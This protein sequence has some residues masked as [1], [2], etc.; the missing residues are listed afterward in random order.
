M[1]IPKVTFGIIVLNGEPFIRYNLRA[2]YPFA[3]QIVV[4]E[5]ASPGAKHISTPDGHSTDETLNTLRDFKAH[6]DPEQKLLILTA[7]DEGYPNGF[8]PGEKHEQSQAYAKRATGDYLWQ[9]D[10]DEFYRP[11]D[12]AVVLDTLQHDE[13]ITALS[14]SQIT[15]WGGLDYITDGWFLRRGWCARGIHRV[16][17]WGPGYHYV[18]H[19]PVTI[20]NAQG[21]DVRDLHWVDGLEWARKGIYMYHYSLLFPKQVIEK[22]EYYKEADW[23][24]HDKAKQWAEESYLMLKKPYHVHNIYDYPSWLE[25]FLGKHPPQIETMYAD[26]RAGRIDTE[27]R[28]TGDVDRLL[29]SPGYR[30]GR[31]CLKFAEPFSHWWSPGIQWRGRLKRFVKDPR[32]SIR[33]LLHSD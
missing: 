17:K 20:H 33:K 12:M 32:S 31:A 8:W 21:V 10:M 1:D 26:I 29:R 5:G 11:E 23:A 13:S 2:L 16:F 6:E 15:F 25:R 3:H 7:E 19:R 28:S 30:L 22:S 24:K 14:F 27:L 18:T 9:V 4:V